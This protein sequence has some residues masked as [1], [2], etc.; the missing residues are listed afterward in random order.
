[1]IHTHCTIAF[2]RSLCTDGFFREAEEGA[3]VR[4]TQASLLWPT[5]TD[6]V[7]VSRGPPLRASHPEFRRT[8]S[9]QMGRAFRLHS[10]IV[11]PQAFTQPFLGVGSRRCN[12]TLGKRARAG[13]KDGGAHAWLSVR[14]CTKSGSQ[15]VRACVK[16]R[17]GLY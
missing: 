5:E 1:M 6:G 4:W 7:R 17:C 16:S 15:G 3:E 9:F 13:R 2:R 8:F 14:A 10:R 12:V 11:S